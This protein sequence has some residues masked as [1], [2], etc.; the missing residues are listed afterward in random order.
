MTVHTPPSTYILRNISDVQVAEPI[1]YFPQTIGWQVLGMIAG[2]ALLFWLYRLNKRWRENRYR[3]EAIAIVSDMR[4]SLSHGLSDQERFDYGQDLFTVMKAVT[5][6]LSSDSNRLIGDAFLSQL[7]L[8]SKE[9]LR[10]ENKWQA[11]SKALLSK[12]YSLSDAE[13]S[14]LTQDCLSWLSE[15]RSEPCL[16]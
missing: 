5:S 3:G 9:N 4:A 1:S 6:H 11:W 14:E 12:G 10:F 2:I 7:D 15:H 13:L 16:N 8:F